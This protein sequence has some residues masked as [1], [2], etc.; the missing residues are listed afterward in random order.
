MNE[1]HP[2]SLTGSLLARKAEAEAE[3]SSS[4]DAG[5]PSGESLDPSASVQGTPILPEEQD[6]FLTRG[7]DL[8]ALSPDAEEDRIAPGAIAG[9]TRPPRGR[10]APLMIL[11]V[12]LVFA[13]GGSAWLTVKL[14]TSGDD[15]IS[16][17]ELTSRDSPLKPVAA[18]RVAEAPPAI[19]PLE[20]SPALQPPP[21]AEPPALLTPPPSADPVTT[22]PSSPPRVAEE[23][24]E[25]PALPPISSPEPAKTAALA[26]PAEIA[27]PPE[28]PAPPAPPAPMAKA[29]PPPPA[30]AK[31]EAPKPTKTVAPSPSKPVQMAARTG[32][33]TYHIQLSS[34]PTEASAKKVQRRLMRRFGSMLGDATLQIKAANLGKKG[35]VY[36]I[37]SAPVFSLSDAKKACKLLVARKQGCFVSGRR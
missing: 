21:A 34:L 11:A 12:M 1:R 27:P 15:T 33:G 24:T 32:G 30:M 26:P 2:A 20:P 13:L 9:A 7:P 5:T 36:R 8:S 10:R 4:E 16:G 28:P 3:T 18:E 19:T 17:V 23:T 14:F 29:E 6:N 22:D 35:T 37:R 25:P 31:A